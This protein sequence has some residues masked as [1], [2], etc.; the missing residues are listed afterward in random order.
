MFEFS[1]GVLLACRALLGWAGQ[2]RHDDNV[3]HVEPYPSPDMQALA[4]GG[5]SASRA[6]TYLACI[7]GLGELE[8]RR[9]PYEIGARLLARG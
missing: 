8:A 2:G 3:P 7:V 9:R 1:F 6:Y 4:L 5:S